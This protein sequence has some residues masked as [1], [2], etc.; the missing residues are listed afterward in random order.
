MFSTNIILV[1]EFNLSC[2]GSADSISLVIFEFLTGNYDDGFEVGE[3][4]KISDPHQKSIHLK[5][6]NLSLKGIE[7]CEW[8]L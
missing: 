8:I 2:H 4:L 5:S 1:V 6:F 3:T 7:N